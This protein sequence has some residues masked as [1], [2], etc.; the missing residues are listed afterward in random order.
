MFVALAL[1][2]LSERTVLLIVDRPRVLL[3]VCIQSVLIRVWVG[4]K[5]C[6]AV[7]VLLL[8]FVH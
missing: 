2:I 8:L 6:L 1:E 5:H 7:L 4:V 3:L